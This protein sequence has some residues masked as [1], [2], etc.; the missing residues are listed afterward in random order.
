M[1]RIKILTLIAIVAVFAS[2]NNQGQSE[3]TELAVPVSVEDVKPQSI[4]QF[5]T[6]TG[7]V[8]ATSQVTV[9]SEM[10]GEYYLQTNPATGR[11][12]KLGDRVQKGQT[13]IRLED[14]EYENSI[15]IEAVEL[16][17]EIS[18][19][20][21]EKQKSLYEKG[22]VT[23]YELRNSEV[24]K[25]NAQ[26]NYE[27]AQL[28][29]AKMNIK[30]PFTGVIVELPNY[31]SG[32]RVASGSPMFTLMSYTDMFMEIN[33]PEKSITELEVGQDVLVTNYTL[34]EDTL[35]G[36]ITQLSPAISTETRTFTG[37]IDIDNPE[38]KLRPGMFVKADIITAEKDS[39][40]VI[41]KDIIMSAGRGKYVFVVGR[42]SAADDRWI[43]TG[44]ENQN[45]V[46]V[47]EGLQVNDRLIIRGFETLRDDSKVKIIR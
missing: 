29:L 26:Y 8:N 33:L 10:A 14:E 46:E 36:T 3:S 17:L 38:L 44:I 40:I 41:P 37:K 15:A 43:T 7:T 22:G 9:N 25:T 21:Y 12:F 27:N 19:Q 32:T 30:A 20:E 28:Q 5:V 45:N 1:K 4:Q 42:N 35:K 13:I 16:N 11:T 24:S 47:L 18:Q 6:T 23:L 39:T 31:T 34:P 2:C